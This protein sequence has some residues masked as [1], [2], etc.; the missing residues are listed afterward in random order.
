MSKT[1]GDTARF[2]RIRSQ[3]RV[4]RARM[5]E[6]RAEIEARKVAANTTGDKPKA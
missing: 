6:L 5:R 4:R 2:H 1:C 3:Q